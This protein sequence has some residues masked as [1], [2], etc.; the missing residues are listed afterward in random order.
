MTQ[1]DYFELFDYDNEHVKK[2]TNLDYTGG[3][4]HN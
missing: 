3:F 4:K 2:Y 1:N